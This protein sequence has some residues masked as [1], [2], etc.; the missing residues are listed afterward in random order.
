MTTTPYSTVISPNDHMWATGE[1]W[2]PRGRPL[3]ARLREPGAGADGSDAAGHPGHAL[4]SRTGVP[5]A[6]RVVSI[7]AGITVCDLDRDGVDF[8]ASEFHAEPLYSDEDVRNV[9]LDRLLNLIW[10]GSLFTAPRSRPLAGI[11]GILRGAPGARR[12][13]RVHDP[14]PA[15]DPVDARWRVELRPDARRAAQP[16]RKLCQRRLRVRGAGEPAVRHLVV[17]SVVR[18]RPDRA[19]VVAQARGPARGGVGRPS[20][21]CRLRQAGG[22]VPRRGLHGASRDGE[23]A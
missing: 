8:C 18:V 10:C 19:P 1:A 13:A 23:T 2:I 3:G 6:A 12:R 21:R 20:G 16:R 5:D 22:S 4:R 11:P 17:V 7:A 9:K 14:R 15:A